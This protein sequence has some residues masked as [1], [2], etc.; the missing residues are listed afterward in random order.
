MNTLEH[1]AT[2]PPGRIR[3]SARRKHRTFLPFPANSQC[4]GRTHGSAPEGTHVVH[5]R[6]FWR[7]RKIYRFS[8]QNG[9]F[10]NDK[11]TSDYFFPSS[12]FPVGAGL[13]VRSAETSYVFLPF[14]ANSQCLPRADTWVR[15]YG[16]IPM[17]CMNGLFGVAAKYTDF[18]L[19][20]GQ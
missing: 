14:P 19:K 16:E 4:H 20:M 11:N 1:H 15:P 17:W 3:V 7:C 9:V 2:P 8:A 13:C 5:E 18:L 6:T 10:K 12:H